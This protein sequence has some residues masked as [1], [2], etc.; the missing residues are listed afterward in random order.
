MHKFT[1]KINISFNVDYI[2]ITFTLCSSMNSIG[3]FMFLNQCL[4]NE[5]YGLMNYNLIGYLLQNHSNQILNSIQT[6]VFLWFDR[7]ELYQINRRVLIQ[8]LSYFICKSNRIEFLLHNWLI[9]CIQRCRNIIMLLILLALN[10]ELLHELDLIV[11]IS[12]KIWI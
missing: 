9:Y 7:I 4:M 6:F 2:C 11:P 10:Y 8:T 12:L 3:N 5:W 1:R